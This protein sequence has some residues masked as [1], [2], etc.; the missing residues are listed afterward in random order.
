[1]TR[2]TLFG[3][4]L[5]FAACGPT[6]VDQGVDDSGAIAPIFT[7][8][9]GPSLA[10]PADE[11]ELRLTGAGENETDTTIVGLP[12][13]TIVIVDLAPGEYQ[14]AMNGRLD[15]FIVWKS[16]PQRVVVLPGTLSEPTISPFAF[17]VA[18]VATTSTLP[19]TGGAPL[20]LTWT[21][22]LAA[23]E[24]R[25]AW[26]TTIDFGTILRDTVVAGSPASVD[27]GPAGTY[28][29]RVLPVDSVGTAGFPVLLPDTVEV[30][31]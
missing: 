21:E 22:L 17:E 24:Y 14:L 26:S 7:A 12:G 3:A 9:S 6:P 27:L 16:G 2:T 4:L 13:D 28:F 25:V 29:V 18:D 8:I 10:P 31:N 1:M 20:E 30:Q 5:V 11:V 15:P 19:L 23:A